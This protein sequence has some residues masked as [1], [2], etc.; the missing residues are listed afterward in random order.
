VQPWPALFISLPDALTPLGG[1]PG[2]DDQGRECRS[3]RDR[4][5]MLEDFIAPGSSIY[6]SMQTVLEKRAP[7]DFCFG[8]VDQST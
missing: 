5:E 6:K 2:N 3:K 7:L 4:N 8:G 1:Y